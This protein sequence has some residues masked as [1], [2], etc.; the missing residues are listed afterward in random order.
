MDLILLPNEMIFNVVLFVDIISLLCNL[1]ITCKRFYTLLS[2]DTI[3]NEL[4]KSYNDE[5]RSRLR[6]MGSGAH[7]HLIFY[8]DVL[9]SHLNVYT[10]LTGDREI[11]IQRLFNHVDIKLPLS[12]S[13]FSQKV[14]LDIIF[15]FNEFIAFDAPRRSTKSTIL[16][17]AAVLI[18][19]YKKGKRVIFVCTGPS[20][21]KSAVESALEIFKFILNFNGKELSE[22]FEPNDMG[23]EFVLMHGV[24]KAKHSYIFIDDI[25][26][27]K[28]ISFTDLLSYENT[29][30]GIGTSNPG[31]GLLKSLVKIDSPMDSQLGQ[32]VKCF[33]PNESFKIILESRMHLKKFIKKIKTGNTIK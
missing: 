11:I 31:N 13:I 12:G 33:V 6:S 27:A 16:I 15:R 28:R 20:G 7:K 22:H 3:L 29:I 5:T 21:C 32:W 30:I 1:K 24:A 14:I 2:S 9:D 23:I 25:F 10:Y 17:T 8:H 18:A 19:Y 26:Y 4:S